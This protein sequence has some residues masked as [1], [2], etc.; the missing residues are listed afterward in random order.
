MHGPPHHRRSDA[1]CNP[2]F[3]ERDTSGSPIPS[4]PP[5]AQTFSAW[6]W[7]ASDAGFFL[8]RDGSTDPCCRL[9]PRPIRGR[10]KPS[11][12]LTPP[13]LRFLF[14]TSFSAFG[15]FFLVSV[16]FLG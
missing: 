13:E 1:Q 3:S 8:V 6:S 16:G 10:T 2:H 5:T 14:R 15:T 4:I 12:T 11:A 7:A 9:S